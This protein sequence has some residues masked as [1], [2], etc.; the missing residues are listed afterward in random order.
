MGRGREQTRVDESLTSA[1]IR[2]HQRPICLLLLLTYTLLLTAC[3]GGPPGSPT[4]IPPDVARPDQ[5]EPVYTLSASEFNLTPTAPAINVA[6]VD[7]AL[8]YDG[9]DD[10]VASQRASSIPEQPNSA[11]GITQY[12]APLLSQPFGSAQS[13]TIQTIPGGTVL[14]ITGRSYDRKYLAVYTGAGVAGWM[15]LSDI[16]LYGGGDQGKNLPTV[17]QSAA[18]VAFATALAQAMQPVPFATI[19]VPPISSTRRPIVQAAPAQAAPV[20]VNSI[21]Q[22]SNSQRSSV[23]VEVLDVAYLDVYAEPDYGAAVIAQVDYGERLALSARNAVG[24]W[25]Q[26]VLPS[27]SSYGSGWAPVQYLRVD[28]SMDGL[29]VVGR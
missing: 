7:R 20:P 8:G 28:A 13:S 15:R 21:V 27:G 16:I 14:T 26:V 3:G 22:A 23:M 19:D 29:P 12:A 25:V 18:P 6:E 2:F 1:F 10:F 9:L 5:P 4:A 17:S 11:L 24:D